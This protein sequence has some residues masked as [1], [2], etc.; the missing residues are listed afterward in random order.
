MIALTV[1]PPP[2][3]GRIDDYRKEKKNSMELVEVSLGSDDGL[4]VGHLMTVYTIATMGTWE[5]SA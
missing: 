5:R 2:L 4:S 3:E 1:P